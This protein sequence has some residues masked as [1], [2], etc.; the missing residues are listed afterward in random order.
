MYLGDPE[1]DMFMKM[2]TEKGREIYGHRFSRGE[3]PFGL[4]KEYKGMNQV[5]AKGTQHMTIQALLTSI[6]TN[7]I[8]I[9]NYEI[10][11]RENT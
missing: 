6:S 4:A 10:K 3:S 1:T 8:K 7:I 2:Q 9:N 11:N 5:R